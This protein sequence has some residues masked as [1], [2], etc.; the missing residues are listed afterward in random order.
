MTDAPGATLVNFTTR[1]LRAS[2]IAGIWAILFAVIFYPVLFILTLG[3]VPIIEIAFLPVELLR[4]PSGGSAFTVVVFWSMVVYLV[5]FAHRL[6]TRQAPENDRANVEALIVP[7]VL[8]MLG[9]AAGVWHLV[10]EHRTETRARETKV[11]VLDFVQRNETVLR[12]AGGSGKVSLYSGA[13][14]RDGSGRYDVAVTGT[15][16][17]Y[18]IVE[19][20]K[21]SPKAKLTLRCTTAIDMAKRDSRWHVCEQ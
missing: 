3:V 6:R 19:A 1:A 21:D 17:I 4:L 18:A 9:F 13:Y 5:V 7:G 14:D 2:G 12:Q 11:L 8:A 10:Q 20:S 16:T 15:N